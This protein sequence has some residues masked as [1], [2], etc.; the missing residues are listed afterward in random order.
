MLP[1][2]LCFEDSHR[3]LRLLSRHSSKNIVNNCCKLN[4][5]NT[6]V[7]LARHDLI[8]MRRPSLEHWDECKPAITVFGLFR[9]GLSKF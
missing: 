4:V 9:V 2:V 6:F 3:Q 7:R 5:N 8:D 1:A